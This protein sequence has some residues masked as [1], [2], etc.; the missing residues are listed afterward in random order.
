MF[1]ESGLLIFTVVINAVLSA[2]DAVAYR[3]RSVILSLSPCSVSVFYREKIKKRLTMKASLE[4]F[5]LTPL[6]YYIL[7]LP[8]RPFTSVVNSQTF[9]AAFIYINHHAGGWAWDILYIRYGR[10]YHGFCS[11]LQNK[12]TVR[13]T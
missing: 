7:R 12:D 8:V 2:V 11:G 9:C 4:R 10:Q 13:R 6:Q 3:I 1:L 5:A